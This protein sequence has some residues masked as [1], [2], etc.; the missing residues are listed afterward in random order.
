MVLSAAHHAPRTN[1][2]AVVPGSGAV[3]VALARAAALAAF[4]L[5]SD[6]RSEVEIEEEGAQLEK[7][8]KCEFDRARTGLDPLSA[9]PQRRQLQRPH[10]ASRVDF[11]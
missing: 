9:R 11:G 5:F 10:L 3:G 7:K 6:E 8:G 4:V 2:A 1:G